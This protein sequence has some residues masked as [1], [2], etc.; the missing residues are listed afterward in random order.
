MTPNEQ[1]AVAV[2]LA[3]IE[4]QLGALVDKVD[5]HQKAVD[6]WRTRTSITLHGD[7]NGVRGVTTRVSLLEQNSERAKWA[8]RAVGAAVLGLLAQAV[9]KLLGR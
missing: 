8:G 6:E 7:G 3:R 9:A 5:D 1:Q 4:A 2:A